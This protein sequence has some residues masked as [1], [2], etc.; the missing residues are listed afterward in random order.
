MSVKNTDE[1]LR[2]VIL[3]RYYHEISLLPQPA[4]EPVETNRLRCRRGNGR[5][6]NIHFLF[7]KAFGLSAIFTKRAMQWK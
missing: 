1:K 7:Q 3:F 6:L 4:M 5:A 2:V